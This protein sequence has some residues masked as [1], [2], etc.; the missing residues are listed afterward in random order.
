MQPLASAFRPSPRKKHA[1]MV[2]VVMRSEGFIAVKTKKY[3][4]ISEILRSVFR[5]FT[6]FDFPSRDLS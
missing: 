6:K 3:Y 5:I 4:G 2:V 1:M